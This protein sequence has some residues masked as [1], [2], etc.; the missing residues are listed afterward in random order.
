MIDSSS[1]TRNLVSV[2]NEVINSKPFDPLKKDQMENSV[3]NDEINLW[4]SIL[5]ANDG[6]EINP[7]TIY[8]STVL[9]KWT[10]SDQITLLNSAPTFEEWLKFKRILPYEVVQEAAKAS[11]RDKQVDRSLLNR[12]FSRQTDEEVWLTYLFDTR[13]VEASEAYKT[14]IITEKRKIT[15]IFATSSR[16]V[17]TL[18]EKLQGV[19]LTIL[20]SKVFRYAIACIPG[21][22]FYFKVQAVVE[23]VKQIALEHLIYPAIHLVS[24]HAP[25]LIRH[26]SLHAYQFYTT[27]SIPLLVLSLIGVYL[28]PN[29]PSL[30]NVLTNV[31]NVIW[32]PFTFSWKINGI[33][34][35]ASTAV[36]SA[37]AS[38]I[39]LVGNEWEKM[40]EKF[41]LVRIQSELE[42]ARAI[43]I[44]EIKKIKIS[45]ERS[46]EYVKSNYSPAIS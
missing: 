18:A 29:K 42:E 25:P 4:S 23:T 13:I 33:P 1:H 19:A 3:Q 45:Q 20:K 14:S 10:A 12:F 8:N 38:T 41:K 2:I 43:W 30:N 36:F 11:L 39:L 27:Y 34:T 21:F 28:T 35:K 9:N 37:I 6:E 26:V 32:L 5:K 40:S 31:K 7:T 46:I 17:Q 15:S 16:L 24:L 22:F 44:K